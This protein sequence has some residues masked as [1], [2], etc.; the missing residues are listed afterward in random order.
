[1]RDDLVRAVDLV[2]QG[3]SYRQAAE[4]VGVTRNAV[5]GACSRAGVKMDA[6]A[7]SANR[8][9]AIS[10][11]MRRRWATDPGFA[12]AGAER[13]RKMAHEFNADP[14]F[15]MASAERMRLLHADPEF[16][17][18]HAER[19]RERMNKRHADRRARAGGS[20]GAA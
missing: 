2:R 15:R 7:A 13:M 8:S 20:H 17:K 11:E 5:A 1:M 4:A 18:A 12:A 6:A 9:A 14:S 16:A 10:A 3:R 19:A